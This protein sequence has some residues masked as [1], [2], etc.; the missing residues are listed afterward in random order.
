MSIFLNSLVEILTKFA[1]NMQKYLLE[2]NFNLYL[3]PDGFVMN[4]SRGAGTLSMSCV[5]VCAHALLR[6]QILDHKVAVHSLYSYCLVN[7]FLITCY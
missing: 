3:I 2:P 5:C 6:T 1:I 7:T 4:I